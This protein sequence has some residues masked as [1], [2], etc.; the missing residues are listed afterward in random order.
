[1]PYVER[2]DEEIIAAYE[3]WLARH[4]EPDEPVLVSGYN[5]YSVRQLVAAIKNREHPVYAVHVEQLRKMAKEYDEDPVQ[6]IDQSGN[7]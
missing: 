6:L 1:M 3:R 5:E 2:T 4:P 7:S